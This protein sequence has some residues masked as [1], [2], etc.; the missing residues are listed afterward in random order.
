MK[1]FLEIISIIYLSWISRS[2]FSHKMEIFDALVVISSF[3]L[4]VVFLY[5]DVVGGLAQL[6][7]FLRFW[8]V[9]RI[10]NGLILGAKQAAD[11]RFS[12]PNFNPH[13]PVGQKVADELGFLTFPRW[14][15]RVFLK[16]ELTDPPQIFDAHLLEN[17]NVSPSRFHF[18]VGFHI[19]IMFWGKW[20][21]SR[22]L[23]F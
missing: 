11:K 8:R 1:F 3:I 4:D 20:F 23:I 15:S 5:D 18:S 17:T 2:L 13:T 7:I 6:I 16:S 10:I 19:K 22:S 21:Y 9:I 12:F 14:M